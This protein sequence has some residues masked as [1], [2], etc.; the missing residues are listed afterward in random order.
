MY[1]SYYMKRNVQHITAGV[2]SAVLVLSSCAVD[3]TGE[4]VEQPGTIDFSVYALRQ[5]AV[6]RAGATGDVSTVNLQTPAQAVGKAGIGIFGFYTGRDLYSHR[7]HKPNFMHNVQLTYKPQQTVSGIVT[8]PSRWEYSPLMYW[9]NEYEGD[10]GGTLA[11]QGDRLS[12]FAY[13][14]Y[15]EVDRT[16]GFID[17]T[18]TD[19]NHTSGSASGIIG[20][21]DQYHTGNPLIHYAVGANPDEAV[22]LCWATAGPSW[23]YEDI[24]GATVERAEG[25]P[26][27][28]LTRM[29]SYT[30]KIGLTLHHALAK[31]N[32][33]VDGAVDEQEGT[34]VDNTSTHIYLRRVTLSGF[35]LRGS[36]DLCNS[37]ASTPLWLEYGGAS[38][39]QPQKIVLNDGRT[40]GREGEPA[41]ASP[42]EEN[43]LLNT[44]LVQTD[45]RVTTGVTGDLQNL[46]ASAIATSAQLVIPDGT[47]L[48]IAIDYDIETADPKL[49]GQSLSDGSTI[50]KSIE[51]R[52]SKSD[53]IT[54]EA[55]KSYTICVHLGLTSVKFD[56]TDIKSWN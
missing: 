34:G 17:E 18:A 20:M 38:V 14:P 21:T 51:C 45:E 28:D 12:F 44:E 49:V 41:G 50:G 55:G 13:A 23:S 46:F 56:V 48:S 30:N 11:P 7:V 5:P 27:I 6:T 47:P 36:L 52:V 10:Y 16:T 8:S 29:K 15:V 1:K 22:D 42:N 32:I 19:I 39:I 40:E 33:Q 9:P 53:I 24:S 31:L 25:M 43:Q 4:Q 35:A 37:T 2:I 54:L 3:T 26:L